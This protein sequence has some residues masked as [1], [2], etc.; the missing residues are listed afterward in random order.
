[1]TPVR[2]LISLA[3][4]KDIH[5]RSWVARN[6]ECPEAVL[7]YMRDNDSEMSIREFAKYELQ[8]RQDVIDSKE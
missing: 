1:M 4:D 3:K 5:V 6:P 8:R 7:R 2:Q